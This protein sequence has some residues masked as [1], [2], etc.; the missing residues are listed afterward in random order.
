[1]TIR[2]EDEALAFRYRASGADPLIECEL[3]V[4]GS[5]YQANGYTTRS[6]AD[7]LGRR[8]GLRAGHR[9]L[10]IGSG[11]GWPGL[12]LAGQS[13]CHVVVIDPV[14]DGVRV[15]R[16]RAEHDRVTEG[17]ACVQSLGDPLPFAPESF[18]AVVHTDVTC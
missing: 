13:G 4:L 7:E 15:A 14:I 5:D 12:Y 1:M 6:Q 10:D 18:D 11:C 16:T 8:V 2:S 9:L 3:E 17:G